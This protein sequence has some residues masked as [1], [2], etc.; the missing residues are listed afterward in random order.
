MSNL[1]HLTVDFFERLFDQF[2]RTSIFA[3]DV[4]TSL[5][6]VEHISP[7]FTKKTG[8]ALDLAILGEGFFPIRFHGQLYY[9]RIG[10]FFINNRGKIAHQNGGVLDTSF[11]VP[12]SIRRLQ[13]DHD[14]NVF[15][16]LPKETTP[17]NI[18]QVKLVSFINPSAL[19]FWKNDFLLP[20]NN[21]GIANNVE[22][23]SAL[24]IVL[25]QGHLEDQALWSKKLLRSLFRESLSVN[26]NREP[27]SKVE[28]IDTLSL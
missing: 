2:F 28:V 5:S 13:I 3:P 20:T 9:T 7:V 16:L 10:K 4:D 18:G 8:K 14:G 11:I 6:R 21:S 22:N 24:P 17:V 25:Q 19:Y 26:K 23:I 27:L 1:I 12:Q 15:V